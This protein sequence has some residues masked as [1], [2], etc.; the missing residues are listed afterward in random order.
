MGF[1]KQQV[2]VALATAVLSAC[3]GGGGDAGSGAPPPAPAP[4]PATSID[5]AAAW[6]NFVTTPNTWVVSGVGSD[7]VS[8]VIS[9]T[10]TPGS[11]QVFPLNGTS[12]ATTTANVATR[13]GG[14][15]IPTTSNISYFNPTTYVLAG[16]RNID[17]N[18]PATCSDTTASTVPPTSAAIGTSGALHTFNDRNGCLPASPSEGTSTTTWSVES[19]TGITYFCLNTTSRNLNGVVEATEQDCVQSATDGTLGPKARISLTQAGGFSLVA[20][21]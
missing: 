19:E 7:N 14:I 3:G 1:G 20:R 6:R 15:D 12:Y 10:L 13:I 2:L 9:I 16:T 18:N 21:N 5:A 11:T 4:T 17:A 8:Y